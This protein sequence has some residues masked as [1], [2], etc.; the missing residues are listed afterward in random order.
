VEEREG[1]RIGKDRKGGEGRRMV[2]K[3][4]GGEGKS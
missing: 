1:R 2:K 3:G 4:K